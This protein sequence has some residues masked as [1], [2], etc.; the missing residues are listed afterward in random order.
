MHI[1]YAGNITGRFYSLTDEEA[2]HC[3]RVLRLKSGDCVHLI[4][5]KG[6]FYTAQIAVITKNE[7]NVKIIDTEA[8][9]EKRDF[10]LHIAI[11]PTKN[12]DRFEWFMEK[13]TEI[14]I[15]EITPLITEH[16]ERKTVK[17]E[18][19]EKIIISAIKQSIK[20]YMPKLNNIIDYKSFIRNSCQTDTESKFIACCNAICNR[21]LKE[22]YQPNHSALIIIGPEG[23]F[24]QEELKLAFESGFQGISLGKS[25]LRTETAGVIACHTINFI[26]T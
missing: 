6:G 22:V 12:I 13:A 25:R 14:G 21:S 23:D 8:E 16:S 20:A 11:A 9:F 17:I 18:R 2:K 4:D 15:D 10:Y 7:C 3:S 1:F 5:G 24:S 26:N 19:L